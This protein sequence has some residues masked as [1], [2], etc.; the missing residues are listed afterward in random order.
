M[1]KKYIQGYVDLTSEEPALPNEIKLNLRDFLDETQLEKFYNSLREF[2]E[3][4]YLDE[5]C[6]G[7][8]VGV[9]TLSG[10]DWCD[11]E[12]TYQVG[13]GKRF[14]YEFDTLKKAKAYLDQN[15]CSEIVKITE[16]LN[17][18]GDCYDTD[19]ETVYKKEEE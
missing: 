17:K 16:Y 6:C 12:V 7:F 4:E 9:I 2:L 18:N 13:D 5:R 3:D 15:G 19:Y 11:K 1:E 14:I 10:M 8:N